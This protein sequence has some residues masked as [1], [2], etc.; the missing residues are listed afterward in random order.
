ME[1]ED[2]LNKYRNQQEDEGKDHIIKQS[3]EYGFYAILG[4]AFLLTLYKIYMDLPFGDTGYSFSFYIFAFSKIF[5]N[6]FL[7]IKNLFVNSKNSFLY[8]SFSIS[9]LKSNIFF[10]NIFNN[11]NVFSSP[12]SCSIFFKILS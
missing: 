11:K 3:D 1:K 2:I 8:S 4:L 12:S 6:S 5:S 7:V 9:F 10:K